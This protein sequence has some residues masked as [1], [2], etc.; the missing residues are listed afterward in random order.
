VA[1]WARKALTFAGGTR[2]I[3]ETGPRNV[4]LLN[5]SI[6]RAFLCGVAALAM[7]ALAA[8]RAS[9]EALLL[10]EADSGKVLHAENATLPWYPA[11]LSKLMT[12]Y[13]T[14]RAVKEGRIKLDTLITVSPKAAAQNPSK[15]GLPVGTKV[16]VDDALKMLLVKSANDMAVVLAEGVSGSI[17]SFAVQMN[18]T[19]L[20]LGMTQSHFDNPNGLPDD[21][22]IVSA[23][24]IAI[25]ARSLIKEFPEYNDY[26]SIPAI[27][28]GRRVMRNY[29]RLIGR[30]PGADGMKTGFIC[31]SGYNLVASATRDGKRLIA[32]VLGARSSHAR[33]VRAAELLDSGFSGSLLS[34]LTPSLGNVYSLVPVK[35]QPVNLKDE[36]CGGRRKRHAAADS[37]DDDEGATVEPDSPFAVSLSHLHTPKTDITAMLAAPP[38]PSVPVVVHVIAPPRK[39]GEA[40]NPSARKKKKRHSRR[41]S[42]ARHKSRRH[43]HRRAKRQAQQ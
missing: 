18:A 25:L 10:I 16:T 40:K 6:A 37:D 20:R 26:W 19:A 38:A 24:D 28:F 23:R 12:A 13:V 1:N 9:A 5:R 4:H 41:A 17:E 34:W 15:M 21:G 35:A 42:R 30:Y 3:L 7:V 43:H 27:K 33:A 2:S 22:Q 32:V 39:A 29:N 11:S 14:L 8:G 31:A 36:V